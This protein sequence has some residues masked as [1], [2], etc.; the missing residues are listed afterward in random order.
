[1]TSAASHWRGPDKKNSKRMC[2]RAG[3]A[4]VLTWRVGIRPGE[5]VS[6][7]LEAPFA[8]EEFKDEYREQLQAMISKKLEQAG[9]A[10]AREAAPAATHVN[11]DCPRLKN[12]TPCGPA[13]SIHLCQNCAKTPSFSVARSCCLSESSFPKLLI[14]G[15]SVWSEWS[16]WSPTIFFVISRS[17]VRSRRVAP[18]NQ[19]LEK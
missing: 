2:E 11:E 3:K 15:S 4:Q 14:S 19:S 7:A 17:P 12:R 6:E 9:T 18:R 13:H 8:P 16:A 1:M 10:A 5:N